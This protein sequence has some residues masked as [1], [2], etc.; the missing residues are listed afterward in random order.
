[1]SRAPDKRES[2]PA[3]SAVHGTFAFFESLS[4]KNGNFKSKDENTLGVEDVACKGN[5]LPRDRIVLIRGHEGTR[6]DYDGSQGKHDEDGYH[7]HR[8]AV[9][10]IC[11]STGGG[12]KTL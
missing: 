4:S 6:Y 5:S 11:K 8:M 2:P 12:E 3:S 10:S 1:M 7:K 9:E